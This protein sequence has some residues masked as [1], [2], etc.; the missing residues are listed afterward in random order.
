M[1]FAQPKAMCN[2]R[3]QRVHIAPIHTRTVLIQ[4]SFRTGATFLKKAN[5]TMIASYSVMPWR[6]FWDLIYE[7]KRLGRSSLEK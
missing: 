3:E 5:V 6:P 1:P 4:M 7:L 2:F